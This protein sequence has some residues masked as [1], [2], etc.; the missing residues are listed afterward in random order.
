MGWFHHLNHQ[1][2]TLT[3]NQEV[4]A[5]HQSYAKRLQSLRAQHGGERRAFE[6]AEVGN[7]CSLV[8]TSPNGFLTF[9]LTFVL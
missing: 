2:D 9:F 6:A 7:S 5:L 3:A 4:L 8:V 1:A